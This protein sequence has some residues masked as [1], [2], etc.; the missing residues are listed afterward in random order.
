MRVEDHGEL[1]DRQ[2]VKY[3]RS[4]SAWTALEESAFGV[5]MGSN[6]F[7]GPDEARTLLG[8]LALTRSGRVLDLGTARGWPAWMRASEGGHSVFGVDVPVEALRLAR[9]AF[10]TAGVAEHTFVCAGSSSALVRSPVF[11]L[12]SE[13]FSKSGC[14]SQPRSR[15]VCDFRPPHLCNFGPPLT[16]D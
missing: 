10:E 9:H 12:F 4:M 11:A 3:A 2:A 14:A 5:A 1:I 7:L 13:R 6:G 16:P 8:A 15:R